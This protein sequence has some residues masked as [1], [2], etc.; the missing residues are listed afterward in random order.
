[1]AEEDLNDLHLSHY[2]GSG[3]WLQSTG[4]NSWGGRP[5]PQHARYGPSAAAVAVPPSVARPCFEAEDATGPY[6]RVPGRA[7][8]YYSPPGTSYTIVERPVATTAIT[9]KLPSRGYSSQPSSHAHTPR[10]A[11]SSA[12]KKRPMSPEEVYFPKLHPNSLTVFIRRCYGCLVQDRHVEPTA[13]QA[14]RR[15]RPT[16]PNRTAPVMDTANFCTKTRKTILSSGPS[17]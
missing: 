16:T 2:G 17:R 11:P 10:N 3:R 9:H 4:G 12:N 15:L 13:R 6:P 7:G 8:L 14:A 5:N 1:M